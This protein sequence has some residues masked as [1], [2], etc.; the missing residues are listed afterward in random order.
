MSTTIETLQVDIQQGANTASSGLDALTKSLTTL[1]TAVKGGAGLTTT[2]GQISKL[3]KALSALSGGAI[4]NLTALATGLQ[5]LSSASGMKLSSSIASQITSIGAAARTLDG[6]NFTP[7]SQLATALAPLG[8]VGK[9][10]LSSTFNQLAK[11]PQLASQ[12]G[13][14]NMGAFSTQIQS[15]VTALAPLSNMGKA[16]LGS[17]LNQLAKLPAIT[18]QLS[19]MD[20][21]AFATQ[22][23]R[24]TAA[25]APLAI[26][27]EKISAGFAKFPARIQKVITGNERLIASNNRS[28]LSFTNLA[29]KITVAV[30]SLRRVARIIGSWITESNSYVE[31]LNLFTV[32]MGEYADSAQAYA[33]KV[34]EIMG[35]DPSEWMRNQG[36]FMTLATGFGVAADKAAIMSKNLTQL[37]YDLSSFFNISYE[38][39][40][41]KLQSGISGELEP[42]RRLGYDLS[43]AK[44]QEIALAN[45]ITE[46][47]SAMTQAE[48][49]QL[50]YY[51]I[52]TQVTTAQGD[53]A[54]TLQ[55]PAN[56]LRILQAAATQAGRALGNI[57]IPALNMI[58]PYAIAFLKVVRAVANALA[59]LFGFSLPEIDYSGLSG[60]SSGA[61]DATSALDDATGAANALKNATLGID[62][63]NVLS[64]DTSGSGSGASVGGGG[65]LDLDLPE[66]DFLGDTVNGRVNEI[67][68]GWMEKVQPVL[69]FITEHFQTILSVALGIGIAL[70]GWKLANGFL[71]SMNFMHLD[72]K[73]MAALMLTLVGFATLLTGAI[74]GW[75]NG[76]DWGNL[77]T[78]LAGMGILVGGLAIKFGTVGAAVGLIIGGIALL[79]TGIRDAVNGSKSLETALA[80]IGGIMAIAGA[81][82]ILIGGWI[83]LVVGAVVA[84]IAMVIM[85]WDEI[86]AFFVGV[87]E[88]IVSVWN[89]CAEWFNT[90]VIQ[91]VVSFFKGLWDSVSGFFSSLWN[92]IVS[93]WNTVASW[94][95]TNVIQP[96]QGFFQMLGMKIGEFFTA[97]WTV[98]SGVWTAVSG[99]FN[100]NVITPIKTAFN[101]VTTA[102]GNFFSGAWST[103]KGVWTAVS[104]WFSE[105]VI[106]PLTEKFS[107]AWDNIKLAFET[108]FEGIKT[109]A[110]SIFNGVIGLIEGV[111]NRVINGI[112]GLIEKFTSVVTWAAGIVGADWSGLATLELVSLPRLAEGGFVDQGQ[113]FIARETGAEMVG[114]IGNKTAV[115]NN[116]QI[117]EG[118]AQ[119]VAGANEG[120]ISA[121]YAAAAM[122]AG[123]IEDN[124]T[125]VAIGDDVIGRSYDR[126]TTKRGVR[127]NSG[128]FAN[129]Y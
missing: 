26:Q 126:Y 117:V 27:M 7:I 82:A 75:V 118:V 6:V 77:L 112:N 67:F 53:M 51:A 71:T 91:P 1:R 129:S 32:A 66:Y 39:S 12:L 3:N 48:K 95:D 42:L 37:G 107:T 114:S 34:G 62:E 55:A 28:A 47:V 11:L 69:D 106:D 105:N 57:F 125:Q 38:D 19:G 100:T 23:S 70:L 120:L 5:G 86:K 89:T 43:Q 76:I 96:V 14:T 30:V 124:A 79:V 92:G 78:M 101:T 108:A 80:I 87:W 24:V 84:A 65:G 90:N 99:W 56:Q 85:Y 49:A 110:K 121:L 60:L 44:L 111:I 113:L 15:L 74:D 127:V 72:L 94:F 2:T 36:I 22:I 18:T 25:L 93:V 9:T 35:I 63:L 103:I 31:N 16:N 52:L 59:T 45:G 40:M 122:L 58:L 50:R 8:N 128:A 41:Q 115:A 81:I 123:T 21:G 61:E 29:A 116:D 98:V 64:N 88:G 46:K 13:S 97:A 83:P 20:M 119:G 54:R 4:S 102:V 33:E 17:V 73:G 68:D 104:G 109:F 10:N